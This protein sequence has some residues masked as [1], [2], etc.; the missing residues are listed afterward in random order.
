MRFSLGWVSCQ[1]ATT[2]AC[3]GLPFRRTLALQRH[4]GQLPYIT[5]CSHVCAPSDQWSAGLPWAVQVERLE[6]LLE[7][8]RSDYAYFSTLERM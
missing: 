8:L 1:H 4:H 7:K 5:T 3:P 6:F 2:A